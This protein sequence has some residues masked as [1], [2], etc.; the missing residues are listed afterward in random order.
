MRRTGDLVKVTSVSSFD[1]LYKIP[2]LQ[3]NVDHFFAVSA[4]NKAGIGAETETDKAIVPK[5]VA[6]KWIYFTSSI[7]VNN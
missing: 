7:F 2:N 4:E 3:S 6:S 5:K 1:T